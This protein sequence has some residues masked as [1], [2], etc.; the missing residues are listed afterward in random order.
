MKV[1]AKR[2]VA[3]QAGRLSSTNEDGE[4][5]AADSGVGLPHVVGA[6]LPLACVGSFS[7][8]LT[9]RP[10]TVGAGAAYGRM[11]RE[12]KTRVA[13]VPNCFEVLGLL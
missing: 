2:V 12:G 9:R 8:G 4:N 5:R 13:A 7:F 1:V 3:C 11:N 6:L 10:A